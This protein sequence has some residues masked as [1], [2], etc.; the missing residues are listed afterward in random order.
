MK[1]RLKKLALSKDTLRQLDGSNLR[2][3]VVGAGTLHTCPGAPYD[4]GIC[5][6]MDSMGPDC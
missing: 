5:V 4:P 6:N 1:K 3:L 2:N